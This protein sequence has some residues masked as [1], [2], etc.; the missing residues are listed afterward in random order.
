MS[1]PRRIIKR[2]LTPPLLVLAVLLVLVEEYLWAWLTAAM[3]HLG[4][5][6]VVRDLEARIG[7]LPPYWAAA[8]F[9]MPAA[10]M[11]PFK[12]AAV[13]AMASGH[14]LLG[15][16]VLLAAKLTGTAL[17]A[18]LYV[19]CEPALM[20]IGWIAALVAWVRRCKAWAHARLENW[21]AWRLVR[22]L[23]GRARRSLRE[24]GVV[25]RRWRSIRRRVG[26]DTGKPMN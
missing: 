12:L 10:I 18:R 23:M 20:T 15:L 3:A 13:W 9:V 8:A 16:S 17:L 7:R 2:L 6:P 24:A 21:P 14:L 5:L 1:P 11:L 26:P 4:R 25:A 19:L 22:R